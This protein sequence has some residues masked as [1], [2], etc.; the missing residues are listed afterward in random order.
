MVIKSNN[1][2]TDIVNPTK[3]FHQLRKHNMRLNPEKCIFGIS[4][5]KF[6]RFMLS[7][8][9]IEA[10][11]DKCRAMLE[12]KSTQNI[13]EVHRL[14]GRLTSLSCFL[15]CVAETTR[16]IIGLLKKASRFD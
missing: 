8:R 15:P 6:L 4:G 1:I 2:P 11:P 5:G 3:V 16:P 7:A 9:G 12:M 13:K 10:N 14:V